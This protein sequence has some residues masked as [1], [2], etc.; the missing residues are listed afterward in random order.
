MCVVGTGTPLTTPISAAF[1]GTTDVV[2][3]TSHGLSSGDMISFNPILSS[4]GISAKQIYF[5]INETVNTFQVASSFAGTPMNIINNGV[6]AMRYNSTIV[7]ILSNV[8]LTMTRPMTL[9]GSNSLTFRP[10][11]VSLPLLKGWSVSG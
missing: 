2:T 8:S 6:G 5:V 4:L 11:N 10:L 3:L 7:S 9:S 1:D